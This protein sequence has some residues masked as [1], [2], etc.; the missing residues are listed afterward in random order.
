MNDGRGFPPFYWVVVFLCAVVALLTVLRL[1]GGLPACPFALVL[2]VVL[3]PPAVIDLV[4][5]VRSR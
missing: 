4:K 5:R 3:A 1:D 2:A